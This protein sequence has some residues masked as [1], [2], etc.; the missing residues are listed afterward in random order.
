MGNFKRTQLWLSA[1]ALGLT[2]AS[3]WVDATPRIPLA[4][5]GVFAAAVEAGPNAAGSASASA[6]ATASP[7]NDT[8]L[9]ANGRGRYIVALK[10]APAASYNGG[11]A[12]LA[13]IPKRATGAAGVVRK[14]LQS[15]E[16][17]AYLTH[18]QAQQSR[19][20]DSVSAQLHRTVVPVDRFQHALN[21]MIVDL[22][23]AEAEALRRRADVLLVDRE[24][25]LKLNTYDTPRFIGATQIWNGAATPSGVGTQGEGMILGVIDSGINWASHS[26]SATGSDG[27]TVKKPAGVTNYLG[28]CSPQGTV[29]NGFTSGG[30]DYDT[31]T[32]TSHCNDKLIGIY[33]FGSDNTTSGQD[34][35]QHG[36]HTAS[37][38]AGSAYDSA[39]ISGSAY[40]VSGIAPHANIIAYSVCKSA[41]QCLSSATVQ[42]VNQAIQDGVHA[43][44]YSIGPKGGDR[45]SPWGDAAL[46]AFL[47][48]QSAGIFVAAAAGN[49]GPNANTVSNQAPWV[50]TVAASTPAFK[51][52]TKASFSLT[53]V[54]GSSAGLPANTQN[55]T[56]GMGAEPYPT[57]GF[58]GLPLI[59]SPNFADG[60]ND[61]CSA[62]PAD[63]F[64]KGGASGGAQGIAVVRLDGSNSSCK[65]TDRRAAAE[66]AGALAAIFVD[67]TLL[68][69]GATGASYVMTLS[70]WNNVKAAAGIDVASTS[71]NATASIGAPGGAQKI[72]IESDD[73]ASFSS[74]G[75][76]LTG[77]SFLKPDIAA[78]G[79][80]IFAAASPT[81]ASGYDAAN[82]A[83]T[84][85]LYTKMSGTSMASPHIAGSS[86]LVRAVHPDWS[87]MEVKSA[88]M[89][90]AAPVK[91]ENGTAPADPLTAGA[92]RV[93]LARAAR[94]ALLFD[95]TSANFA[96]AD[97]AKGGKPETL[98]LPSYYAADCVGDCSF[99]RT[100]RNAGAAGTWT[101]AVSG[102]PSGSYSLDKTSLNPG[103]GSRA[104]FNL[105]VDSTKLEGG[106]WTHGQ[107]TLTPSASSVPVQ[108][109]PIAIRAATPRLNVDTKSVGA[110]IRT[111]TSTTQNVVVSNAGNPTLNW[112][113]SATK[114]KGTLV[115]QPANTQD[116][117]GA[118][119]Y[120]VVTEETATARTSDHADNYYQADW[121]DIGSDGTTLAELEVDGFVCAYIQFF[122]CF[123]SFPAGWLPYFSKQLAWRVWG[124]NDGVP[125]GRPGSTVAGDQQATIEVF[126]ASAAGVDY[127]GN[128]VRI[129]MAKAGLTP[130]LKAGRYWLNMAPNLALAKGST[131][132]VFRF[133][134]YYSDQ[135]GKA[136]QSQQST[137][138]KPQ[139]SWLNS[140]EAHTGMAM[141]VVVN[142]VCGAP[143]LSYDAT[144]GSLGMNGTQTVAVTMNAAG[145]AA[146]TYKTYLCFSGNGTSPKNFYN[147]LGDA[148]LIPVTLTVT[149]PPAAPQCTAKPAAALYSDAVAIDC[150]GVDAGT[151][152]AIAGATCTPNPADSS[153]A[154][155]CTGKADALGNNPIL[156][157]TNSEGL[158]TTVTVPFTVTYPV[159]GTISGLSGSL[160]LSLSVTGS[161]Q[162]KTFAQNGD[163]AFDMPVAAGSAWSVAVATQP[164]GQTC[165]AVNASGSQ[166]SAPVNSVVVSCE[167]NTYEVTASAADTNGTIT[168]AAQTVSHGQAAKFSVT[169][170]TG[171]T[172]SVTD[173]CGSGGRSAGGLSGGTYT[174]PSVTAP[175]A[176]T[177]AFTQIT[178]DVTAV[179]GEHGTIAPAAQKVGYGSSVSFTVTPETGYSA[180]V[181]DSCGAGGAKTGVLTGN[182]YAVPT[183][184]TACSVQAYFAQSVLKVDATSGVNGTITPPTQSILYGNPATFTVSP[185]TGYDAK[186]TDS[187]G[188]NGASAGTLAG[189][190]YTIASVTAGCTV[191]A[192]FSLQ[193]ITV[194]ASATNANGTITPQT[195]TVDYRTAANFVLAANAG[196]HASATDTCG[197]DGGKVGTLVGNTY[198]IASV[199]RACAVTANF[200]AAAL[201]PTVVSLGVSPLLPSA[202]Q[203][204]T[205]TATVTPVG[206]TGN[207]D[208]RLAAAAASVP[209][210]VAAAST[211]TGTV[212]FTDNGTVLGSVALSGNTA[213][214]T[215][216]LTAG[217]HS[218]RAGYSGDGAHASQVS[219]AVTITVNAASTSQTMVAAPMLNAYWLAVLAL[220][221]GVLAL[222]VVRRKGRMI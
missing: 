95:E 9:D 222:Q 63:T 148:R 60:S 133:A 185:N 123:L 201:L 34:L 5:A 120:T 42:A 46:T 99:T 82:R 52:S 194:T 105:N 89:T 138:N 124:D 30:H 158:S 169:S 188:V 7:S 79:V 129:D 29:V 181:T 134:A 64:R 20:V 112:S 149:A 156:T 103:S 50:T 179:A 202:G 140:A 215:T 102:L 3:N 98:N 53:T 91:N 73:I 111:G 173:T 114:L 221:I 75:P 113:I 44:N 200:T 135:P 220:S 81:E 48:A 191:T 212:T 157:S 43:L 27:H 210:A 131:S 136:P 31:A 69:I 14:D 8:P 192:S 77:N 152:N 178:V 150:T 167:T 110:K 17:R 217:Q 57:T 211:P 49:D 78:P 90:T 145:L 33:N 15:A 142:A 72:P 147:L 193:K 84:G 104:S 143:W 205:F 87:A 155:R 125:N 18:L 165:R 85:D 41:S 65:S 70:D 67:T 13:G 195:Q 37:T 128:G 182:T 97:P 16:A 24:R 126:S 83:A 190:I 51:L 127:T 172:P 166:L 130:P 55:I 26:F 2:V 54:N 32:N 174:V 38:A 189:S 96:K 39:P 218:L 36:S 216:V 118:F 117:S 171:Y 22:T 115:S 109:L 214:L 203:A 80:G 151:T 86:L 198:T 4:S 74:R 206:N 187:C 183:V 61:G 108:H 100:V 186:V 94:A 12:G 47:N 132:S 154:I 23:G 184:T 197:A 175:C 119:D 176:V 35:I 199:T 177:A 164:I 153:G 58:D 19:F 28:N 45:D 161:S 160:E 6:P 209:A 25:Y 144:N 141:E 101:I 163:F 159:G 180:T 121:F 92:G 40:A 116:G 76:T 71:G 62:Y 21:G 56:V 66:K 122:G 219:T 11:V 68:D 88:L 207:A 213:S 204:V 170:K 106:K 196:Y 107:L 208:P 10:E 93:D 146:G 59:Q 1:A 162:T 139:A 168:P 137:P